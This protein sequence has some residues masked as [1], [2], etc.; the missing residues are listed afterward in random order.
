[1]VNVWTKTMEEEEIES[2]SYRRRSGFAYVDE[3]I[4]VRDEFS[5]S[6]G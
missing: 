3:F 5:M 2:K 6:M 1:M 4:F